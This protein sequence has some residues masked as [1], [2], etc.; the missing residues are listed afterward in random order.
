MAVFEVTDKTILK[1]LVRR[2]LESERTQC[3]FDEGELAYTIDTKRVFV[4]DGLGGGGQV[5]GNLYQGQ[6]PDAYSVLAQVPGLQFGDLIYD[7]VASTLYA[8]SNE[9]A[10]DLYD[11][12]PRYEE[13]VL[14]KTSSPLG[15]V[16]I[17]E[18]AFGKYEQGGV[19][20]R[21][22][23]YFDYNVREPFYLTQK[24]LELNTQ[25]WA[26]TT[27]SN[28][29]AGSADSCFYFGD[30]KTVSP[31]NN[32]LN[33]RSRINVDVSNPADGM[34]DAITIWGTGGRQLTFGASGG[35]GNASG[36]TDFMGLSGIAFHPGTNN[37]SGATKK[38][39]LTTTGNAIFYQT[40]GDIISPN[41]S[42]YGYAKFSDSMNVT[43]NLVVNGNISAFGDFSVFE[44]Y[45]TI[46][47]S[48][49]IINSGPNPAFYVKQLN[50]SNPCVF[51]QNSNGTRTIRMDEDGDCLLG[52][53]NWLDGKT[54]T[55]AIGGTI[56]GST[57]HL[58]TGE[59]KVRDGYVGSPV[60]G[61]FSV[62]IRGRISLIG[63]DL[64]LYDSNNAHLFTKG[65]SNPLVQSPTYLAGITNTA[66]V[67][68][69]C[70]A[71][72]L[73]GSAVLKGVVARGAATGASTALFHGIDTTSTGGAGTNGGYFFQG[74]TNTGAETFSVRTNG[75]GY[76][77]GTVYVKGDVIAFFTSDAKYKN[78][79]K[80]IANPIDKINKLRGVTFDW[81]EAE[82][83]RL[84]IK[85]DIGVIAQEVERVV[86]QV[87]V[88]REN[89]DKAVRYEKLI[90]LL[91][92]G[93]KELN[94][95]VEEL[96]EK[97]NSKEN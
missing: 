29:S 79:V 88:T 13:N 10:T 75:D 30:I 19:D 24:V 32:K 90:P 16:R 86:P 69:D 72:A 73:A 14:E 81:T 26:L 55:A 82:Q 64:S 43:G 6:F 71:G 33:I 50:T 68:V 51:F 4:G 39:E 70:Q 21:K 78:N 59:C 76:F 60:S 31:V 92:E 53:F 42:V 45:T 35:I 56:G 5:V 52:Y 20:K 3:R 93:I 36:Q 9:D 91:I 62:D 40:G 7:D 2:G 47:S 58:I 63:G 22:G 80:V 57:T 67:A 11:V 23:F 1:I 12:G 95:K 27:K 48:L 44:T 46:T 65:Y 38:F 28:F 54:S 17:A 97:L 34:T 89:G 77:S 84:N 41:F 83:K 87:T 49:S 85:E 25:Y 37:P 15:K 61:Q 96:T 94:T 74:V 66:I 8:V 18:T